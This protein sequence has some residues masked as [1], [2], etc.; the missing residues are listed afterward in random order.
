MQRIDRI[1]IVGCFDP[2]MLHV[3]MPLMNLCA[4]RYLTVQGFMCSENDKSITQFLRCFPSLEELSITLN[5]WAPVTILGSLQWFNLKEVSLHGVWT[6][7]LEFYTLFRNHARTLRHFDINNSSLTQ[8]SWESLFTNIRHLGSV[9]A[10]SASGEL[11]GRTA[12]GTLNM[13]CGQAIELERFM[14]SPNLDWP[15]LHI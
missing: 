7:E 4:V 15:F 2:T 6:A 8:G 13:D 10:V 11:Y 12:K 9:S 5:G 3:D 1:E 14:K